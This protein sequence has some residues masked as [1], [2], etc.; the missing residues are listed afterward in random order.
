MAGKHTSIPFHSAAVTT[1]PSSAGSNQPFAPLASPRF[2]HP[3]RRRGSADSYTSADDDH[4]AHTPVR[5]PSYSYSLTSASIPSSSSSSS[6]SGGRSHRHHSSPQLG[7]CLIIRTSSTGS[8]SPR[9]QS[10]RLQNP[11]SST[12]T[13]TTTT[14]RDSISSSSLGDLEFDVEPLS[15]FSYA[16]PPTSISHRAATSTSSAP[17]TRRN[18][19][20]A[21][22]HVS[23]PAHVHTLTQRLKQEE[24]RQQRTRV[25]EEPEEDDVPAATDDD[26]TKIQMHA[27]PRGMLLPLPD[28]NAE[29]KHLLDH[30]AVLRD[31]I[32]RRLGDDRFSQA[33]DLWTRTRRTEVSDHEWLRRSRWFLKGDERLWNEWAMMVGWDHSRDL[34]KDES[35]AVRPV[36]EYVE[37]TGHMECLE[38]GEEE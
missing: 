1:P 32:R 23:P 22:S 31:Q 25:I 35:G 11:S 4:L 21:Y 26:E 12:A 16:P 18:S 8:G 7:A 15:P 5:S 29:M 20:D 2:V 36:E 33:T 24:E 3:A 6:S 34:D 38:E 13:S 17:P 19:R 27:M 9:S 30:N 10:P 14:T 28:R 37:R